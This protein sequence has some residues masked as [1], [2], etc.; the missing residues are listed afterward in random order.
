MSK[1]L[2][3]ISDYARHRRVRGLPGG[4]RQAIYKAIKTG[5]IKAEPNGMLIPEKADREWTAIT[6]MKMTPIR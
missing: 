4:T 1:V 5:R 2:V 6:S 3:N